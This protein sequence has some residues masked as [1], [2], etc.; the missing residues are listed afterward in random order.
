MDGV[1]EMVVRLNVVSSVFAVED[2][3]EFVTVVVVVVVDSA[4]RIRGKLGSM[5]REGV[6]CTL[7]WPRRMESEKGAV[8]LDTVL[9]MIPISVST[10]FPVGEASTATDC[11]FTSV[12]LLEIREVLIDSGATCISIP[13]VVSRGR[14]VKVTSKSMLG[15][16]VD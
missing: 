8:S 1:H 4:Q 11:A 6:A 16:L 2:L 3:A 14:I 12:Q 7:I 9:M 10:I 13:R 5:V 15:E